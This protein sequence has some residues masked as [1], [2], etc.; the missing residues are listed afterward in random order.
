MKRDSIEDLREKMEEKRKELN[1]KWDGWDENERE[2]EGGGILIV[3]A[4]I[5]A[6]V[7]VAGVIIY[8]LSSL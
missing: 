4:I 7:A 8:I 5:S 2:R 3:A 1:L 6:V